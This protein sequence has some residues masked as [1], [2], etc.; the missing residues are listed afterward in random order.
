MNCSICLN[1]INDKDKYK[2]KCNHIFHEECIE[3]WYRKSQSCPLCRKSK[4]D[5]PLKEYDI[6]YWKNS[7]KMIQKIEQCK[8]S[9]FKV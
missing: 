7:N 2:T 9:L 4:F 8:N 3:F 5:I 6:H 1:E